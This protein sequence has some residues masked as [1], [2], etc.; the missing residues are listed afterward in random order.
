[1]SV[2]DVDEVAGLDGL[3]L[4]TPEEWEAELVQELMNDLGIPEDRMEEVQEYI[5]ANGMVVVE[6]HAGNYDDGPHAVRKCLDCPEPAMI[7]AGTRG[8]HPKRCALHTAER[9]KWM[10][11]GGSRARE[12][13]LPCCVQY[14]M[15]DD[16][17]HTGKCP[18]CRGNRDESREPVY[19]VSKAEA[20]WLIGNLGPADGWHIE[21]PG[22]VKGWS[23]NRGPDEGRTRPDVYH[24][25]MFGDDEA[26]EWLQEHDHWFADSDQ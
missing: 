2:I 25:D 9:A 6:G 11:N 3:D 5:R 19:P 15:D 10:A 4:L 1:V 13:Y 16:P 17:G 12:P 14:Q 7:R 26:N 21:G 22:P 8:P 24:P 20:E 23:T 18:Q